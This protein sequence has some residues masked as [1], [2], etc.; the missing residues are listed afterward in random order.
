[1]ITATMIE[2]IGVDGRP[3]YVRAPI[4]FDHFCQVIQADFNFD[5]SSS[6]TLWWQHWN[7]NKFTSTV[8]AVEHRGDT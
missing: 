3:V 7:E 5:G 1:M 2:V 6:Y 8:E 4:G